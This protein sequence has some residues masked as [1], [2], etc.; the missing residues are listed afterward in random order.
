MTLD[1]LDTAR[2][3]TPAR[4]NMAGRISPAWLLTQ[5]AQLAIE[6][7]TIL[8]LINGAQLNLLEELQAHSEITDML[9][10]AAHAAVIVESNLPRAPSWSSGPPRVRAVFAQAREAGTDPSVIRP[11][12]ERHARPVLDPGFREAIENATFPD[13]EPKAL[14]SGLTVKRQACANSIHAGIGAAHCH[15]HLT[16]AE[17]QRRAV[18]QQ[19]QQRYRQAIEDALDDQA[20]SVAEEWVTRYGRGPL[21]LDIP[22][23]PR[24]TGTSWE[25]SAAMAIA[26]THAQATQRLHTLRWPQLCPRAGEI[27]GAL[28]QPTPV[29]VSELASAAAAR[30]RGRWAEGEA[31][32]AS[33]IWD[34][35]RPLDHDLLAVSKSACID[36]HPT[37]QSIRAA[38]RKAATFWRHWQSVFDDFVA[39][40]GCAKVTTMADL[41]TFWQHMDLLISHGQGAQTRWRLNPAAPS[42]WQCLQPP[43]QLEA[44]GESV[45]ASLARWL[46]ARS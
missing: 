4:L 18:L 20:M 29:T 1:L 33:E 13:A 40:C 23:P 12:G 10:I 38:T 45:A 2:T 7:Q 32:L 8:R 43:G 30:S 46:A 31:W 35:I 11:P 19:A 27:L 9:H 34:G 22:A 16:A 15:A 26:E 39:E 24:P 41:L 17:Q 21:R 36:E 28:L 42:P 6:I 25:T 3:V 14:C 37:V 5:A 44:Q